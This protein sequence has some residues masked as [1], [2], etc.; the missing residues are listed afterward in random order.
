MKVAVAIVTLCCA[1]AQALGAAAADAEPVYVVDIE[2]DANLDEAQ[3]AVT[4][5]G[6]TETKPFSALTPTAGTFKKR[7]SGTL[8]GSVGMAGFTGTFRIEEGAYVASL[9]GMLGPCDK[10]SGDVVVSDGATVV[11]AYATAKHAKV[12]NTFRISGA[13]SARHPCAVQNACTASQQDSAIYGNWYLE[14]DA[15][16]GSGAKCSRMDFANVKIFLQGHALTFRKNAATVPTFVF[17]ATT[18]D[19]AGGRIVVD[20]ASFQPQSGGTWNR[21]D[22]TSTLSFTNAPTYAY[23]GKGATAR[24]WTLVADGDM[25]I[26]PG[27]SASFMSGCGVTNGA[28]WAGD[29]YLKRGTVNIRNATT[30]RG[31]AVWGQVSGP[32]DLVLRD[33]WLHLCGDDNVST[34]TV[35]VWPVPQTT[36]PH[37][38]DSGLALFKARSLNPEGAGLVL[39]NAAL[40]LMDDSVRY[41]LP[42]TM[43]DVGASTNVVISGGA[44]ASSFAGLR[45]TGAGTLALQTRASVTGC[46]ELVEGVVALP[47]VPAELQS[48]APG[49]WFGAFTTY[50]NVSGQVYTNFLG[51]SV[52]SG[53]GWIQ[54]KPTYDTPFMANSKAE[55][56][57]ADTISNEVV[58]GMSWLKTPTYPPW[59][60][61][62]NVCW[63]GYVWNRS[64]TTEVWTVALAISGYCR[65]FFDGV[66]RESTDDNGAVKRV[67]LTVSPGPHSY[68][69]KVNPRNYGSP[70]SITSTARFPLWQKHMGFAIDTLGRNSTNSL[71]YVFP[72]NTVLPWQPGGDGALFTLDT[73]ARSDFSP[74][75]LSSAARPGTFSNVV[76]KA[77]TVLDLGA[78]N[79]LPLQVETFAGATTVRNGGLFVK[80]RLKLTAGDV[81]N[82]GL[83]VD[84]RLTF[85]GGAAFVFDDEGEGLLTDRPT[86]FTVVSAKD[87]IEGMPPF[88]YDGEFW[89]FGLSDDGKSVVATYVPSGWISAE[90]AEVVIAPNAPP[91]TRYAADLLT[92]CLS[93]ALGGAVPRVTSPTEGK[94]AIFVGTNGW[95]RAAGLAPEMLVRDSFCTRV[96]TRRA[97][98]AGCDDPAK[99]L[100]QQLKNGAVGEY[101]RATVFG[102]YD[103]LERYVG[104]R[105]YFPGELGTVVPRH[106]G[107]VLP[108]EALSVTPKMVYR[109]DSGLGGAAP[110]PGVDPQDATGQGRAKSAYRLLLREQ[111]GYVRCGHG[112]NSLINLDDYRETHPEYFQLRQNGTRCVEKDTQYNYQRNQLCHTSGI[113]DL[114]LEAV[115]EKIRNG[116]TSVDV[117]PQDGMAVCWCDTCQDVFGHRQAS[118]YTLASG[119]ATELI[120]SNTVRVAHAVT[121]AGLDGSVAQMAYGTYRNI[122]SVDIPDNVHVV[123]A[124]GG[125]WAAAYT[126][127]FGLNI[128]QM[129]LDFIRTWSEKLGRPVSWTWTYPMKNYG[130][131]MAPGVPQVAPRAFAAFYNRAIPYMAG[132]FAESNTGETLVQ[133]YLNN[134]VFTRIAWY[135]ETDVEPLL[136]EHHRLMFGPAREPM[137]RFF[138]RIEQIWMGQIAIPSVIGETEFGELNGKPVNIS[139]PNEKKLW[140]EIYTPEVIAELD[141]YLASAAAAAP[142]SVEARRV[143]WIR[144]ELF[145]RLVRGRRDY[146]EK[147]ETVTTPVY[148]VTVT[149]GSRTAPVYLDELNVE[150]H[151][152]SKVSTKPFREA[153]LDFAS[154]PAVFRKKGTGWMVSSTNGSMRAFTGEIEIREGAFVVTDNGQLGAPGREPKVTVSPG[155][156]LALATPAAFAAGTLA[157]A[158]VI[159]LSGAGI[160]GCGALMNLLVNDQDDCI[161]GTLVLADDAVLSGH[162][163]KAV[164]FG[165]GSVCDLNGHTLTVRKGTKDG[166][167]LVV[168]N[169]AFL[170]PGA[171]VWDGVE[172]ALPAD[173]AAAY[174]PLF[175][176]AEAGSDV[177]VSGGCPGADVASFRKEGA[178]RTELDWNAAVTGTLELAEGTLALAPARRVWS[179]AAGLWKGVELPVYRNAAGEVLDLTTNS[180]G[181]VVCADPAGLPDKSPAI[182]NRDNLSTL[183]NEVVACTDLMREPTYPPWIK[184]GSAVWSGYVWNRAATNEVWT[185]AVAV[186]GYSRLFVDG[187]LI[188]HT[189]DNGRLS[190]FRKTISP[191]PHA[192]VFKVNP[193]NYSPPGSLPGPSLFN[194]N[195]KDVRPTWGPKMGL[196]LDRLGRTSSNVVDYVFL[197]NGTANG[198]PGGDGLVF[199]RDARD[200]VDFDAAELAAL[201][202]P[203]VAYPHVVA[204]AGTELDLGEGNE[205]PLEVAT[206]EGVTR[207]R[208]G[209]LSVG[210]RLT[211]RFSDVKD[212]DGLVVDGA[213][214]LGEG[215]VVEFDDG[216]FVP[217][218]VKLRL[219]ILT[220]Q[221]G[222]ADFLR[223][224]RCPSGNWRFRLS[225]DGKSVIARPVAGF[226]VMLQ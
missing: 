5:G 205:F 113:W 48:L 38:Y 211:I 70:G 61:Y 165:E 13:G 31:Y 224:L 143:A 201:V 27:G 82:G 35:G 186:C 202:R 156:S 21:G 135:G 225:D 132:G 210:E 172:M 192:F 161:R 41:E 72:E 170:N 68:V 208:N 182:M 220:A 187:A 177:K 109:R 85:S 115:L 145:D 6:V 53:K 188:A 69:F 152:G 40:R 129:Q 218:D 196:A 90:T 191:G 99:D 91:V 217:D 60:A 167:R 110:Y 171:V 92:N 155:A 126:N 103:F 223:R 76:A 189:D 169:V 15:V 151:K 107:L 45:K 147:T 148:T 43:V 194:V 93:Q 95:S 219:R 19:P 4:R 197:E 140:T 198:G 66:Y 131:L 20:G 154:G 56:F 212:G 97:F 138:D 174:Q 9:N 55:G 64:A 118:E 184:W 106:D 134:Y 98:V 116:A 65:F 25:T 30:N 195:G 34:G 176:R 204:R 33:G 67:R 81:R 203:G 124:V 77:G 26:S 226:S 17:N 32:G 215:T 213:L 47:A 37:G 125:P 3:V 10:T 123:L 14:D 185:F 62:G 221:D 159:S 164:G 209:G 136:A 190:L 158:N 207:V 7:G 222:A 86:V 42:R 214:T 157:L 104:C 102:V 130:R 199:T 160:D 142:D 50:T 141:G 58:S 146:L 79:V 114:F 179:L 112:Q 8:N 150:V 54:R 96:E 173:E 206:W 181:E 84:G 144:A 128:F 16:F 1:C 139:G 108:T 180:T 89:T 88:A 80:R 101:E 149:E 163:A 49:L 75:E 117:M 168:G 59:E 23:Y 100:A 78:G 18:V 28:F 29:L 52:P 51:K 162:S 83:S 178:G 46:L 119:Y 63:S 36:V 193:R 133:N 153:C 166:C 22:G 39:T 74:D 175:V 2:A 122:P 121:E 44:A 94:F 200:V 137:T 11:F 120:W 87:G 73:R 111:T 24:G 105:F 216:G 127:Y 12:Y 71:D 183:S 57:N